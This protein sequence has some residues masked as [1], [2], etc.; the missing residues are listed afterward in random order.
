MKKILFILLIA[1]NAISLWPDNLVLFRPS[2]EVGFINIFS[3]RIRFGSGSSGTDFDYVADGGQ[4]VLFPFNRISADIELGGHHIITFLYQPIN[5][6]STVRTA[7]AF[8][9]AGTP[10]PAD[11]VL[12][13]R[14][15]FD[16]YRLSYLYD[17]FPEEDRILAVGASLQLRDA[18][19]N[20]A[21]AD[22]SLLVDKRDVGPVPVIKFRYQEKLGDRFWIGAEIDGFYANIKILNGSIE[23]EITGSILD[24]SLRAGA[25]LNDELD[26]FLNFRFLGGG[27]AGTENDENQ[28]GDTDDGFTDN[29]LAAGSVTLGIS[30]S[31]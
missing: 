9:M 23:N 7:E 14:Y 1:L 21:S 15:G 12:D 19:I 22:G 18:V 29:Q 27:A 10:F 30:S 8:S 5:I 13:L 31:Y 25:R 20:F 3:H 17:F 6:T 16:F 28:D 26:I 4:D 11:S 24:A 2:V